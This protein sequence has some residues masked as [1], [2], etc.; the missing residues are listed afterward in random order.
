[1]KTIELQNGG[2][3]I[4]DDDDF[5]YISKYS[6]RL[7]GYYASRSTRKGGKGC[8]TILMHR[9]INKTPKGMYTD[10]INGN[11][12]DNRKNNLRTVTASQ[13]E[14]NKKPSLGSSQYKGVCWD[15]SRKRWRASIT[16]NGKQKRL[17]DFKIEKEAAKAYNSK[18]IEL[19][20]EYA[21]LNRI[22]EENGKH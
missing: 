17:G 8:K 20:G 14:M 18:A 10:H 4:I 1:M 13:N 22:G 9:E 15:K 3:V 7:R 16:F 2:K 5:D 19:F 12:L 21:F 11:K 6:W